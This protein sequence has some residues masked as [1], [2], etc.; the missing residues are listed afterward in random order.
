MAIKNWT[1]TVESVK[2]TAARELYLNNINHSNHS[3]TERII[4]IWGS[5]QTTLNIQHQCDKRRLAQAL[6]RKGGRPPTPAMEYVFTLPKHVRPSEQQ[7][8]SMLKRIINTLSRSMGEKPS[9]FNNIVR[10]VLHQQKQDQTRGTG[11]HLHVLIGKFNSGKYF[12]KL[13]QKGGIHTAK[14]GFNAAVMAELGISHND[15]IARQNSLKSAKKRAPQWKVKAAREKEA[16]QQSLAVVERNL[17]KVFKQCEK[18]LQA[19]ECGDK[20][21]MNRQYNRITKSLGLLD[22]VEIRSDK[23]PQLIDS[24]TTTIDAK[25]KQVQPL[26]KLVRNI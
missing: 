24:M 4:N 5:A 11:D 14:L 22:Q 15:Y 13:Q 9:D 19:F 8:R 18:W 3:H 12:D 17:N 16:Q 2:S 20:K 26:P 25:S 7:W 10:A 6:K 23:L 21:Q 1:V